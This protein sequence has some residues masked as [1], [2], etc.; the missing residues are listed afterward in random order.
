MAHLTARGVKRIF[1]QMVS[2]EGRR[3]EAMFRRYGFKLLNKSEITKYR[4]LHPEPV[5]LSTVLRDFEETPVSREKT[6]VVD[7]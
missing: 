5:F 2:F 3:G 4:D 7:P 6:V 1:G